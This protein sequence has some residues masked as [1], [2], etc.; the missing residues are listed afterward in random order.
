MKPF[1]KAVLLALETMLDTSPSIKER[2]ERREKAL[3][4]IND[5]LEQGGERW[6]ERT[7]DW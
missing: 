6:P 4:A 5:A 2:K 3:K 1:E 7:N